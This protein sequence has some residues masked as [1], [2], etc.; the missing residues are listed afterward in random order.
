MLTDFVYEP[1]SKV[2]VRDV[3]KMSI[4]DLVSMMSSL[5]S[6]TAYWAGGVLF[7]SFA[8]TDS[9]ELAKKE[10][11]GHAYLDKIIFAECEAFTRTVRSSTNIEIGVVNVE[12]S[13]L[14]R[15]LAVW[16]KAHPAWDR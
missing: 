4:D 9:E 16:L 10:I 8:M 7:V 5:E 2:Y 3:I 1:Y 13:P 11:A 6:A 12:K 15:N 14:Y